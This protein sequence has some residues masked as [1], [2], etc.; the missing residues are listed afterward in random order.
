MD[1][2]PD[3][4]TFENGEKVKTAADFETRRKE[5]LDILQREEY[6]YTPPPPEKVTAEI[7][8]VA[9]QRCAGHAVEENILLSFDTGAGV[10]SFPIT[11]TRPTKPGKQPFFLL[12]NFRP[13]PYDRYAPTEEIIDLGYGVAQLCYEDITKDNDDFSD[14]IAAYYPREGRSAWGKIGMWAFCGSRVIDYLLTRPEVDPSA[15]A[16][17]GHSR[18]GKTALWCAAQDPR[19]ALACSN[20]SGCSGAAYE[21]VKIPEGETIELICKKFPYWFCENYHRYAGAPEAR[22][23]DQHF[24][25]AAI[26]PRYVAI[27]SANRDLWA[28]PY[29]EQLSCIGASPAW[30]LYGLRGYIGKEEPAS[31]GDEFCDGEIGYHLRE[32]IHFLSRADWQAYARFFD[33]KRGITKA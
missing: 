8:E 31:V 21:R 14:G 20:D 25:L 15:I 9:T 12:L 26:A 17:V 23:F 30:R 4:L 2:T 5:L 22:P 19:V 33:R 32:G 16:V 10:F 27:G 11:L 18:L 29:G 28:D 6:G 3:L 7:R 24:L 1:F 13:S